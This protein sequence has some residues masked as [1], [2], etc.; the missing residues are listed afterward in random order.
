MSLAERRAIRRLE[1]YVDEL[2]ARLDN[3]YGYAAALEAVVTVLAHRTGINDQELASWPQQIIQARVGEIKSH[4][5]RE[6]VARAANTVLQQIG[7]GAETRE[8]S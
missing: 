4:W 1:E 3:V 6:D 5:V 7:R 2:K 8:A